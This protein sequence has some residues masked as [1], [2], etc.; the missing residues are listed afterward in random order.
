MGEQLRLLLLLGEGE[1]DKPSRTQVSQSRSFMTVVVD[2]PRG[3]LDIM[4]FW[5]SSGVF[6]K[7]PLPTRH[8]RA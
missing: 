6:P 8:P 7:V 4:G 5:S 1:E 2:G 3:C